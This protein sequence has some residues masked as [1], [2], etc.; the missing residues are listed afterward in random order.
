[1]YA[2]R[3]EIEIL[4]LIGATA[5]FIKV[6]YLLEGAVLGTLGGALSLVVLR[7]GFEFYRMQLGP[8]GRFL[9]VES[10][11]GFF[12]TQISLAL[13]GLGLALGCLGSFVSLY[14]FG[15]ARA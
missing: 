15:R 11:F 12:P 9:G 7:G 3:D 6:P 10:G 8:A 1:L 13:I 4:R 5:A 2:R 14:E